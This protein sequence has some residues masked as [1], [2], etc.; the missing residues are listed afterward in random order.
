[1]AITTTSAWSSDVLINYVTAEVR[2]LEPMLHLTRLGVQRDVPKG[3]HQLAFPQTSRIATSSVSTISE[4]VDPTAVTWGSTAYT[5]GITQY[6]LIVQV[7]DV[8]VRNSAIEVIDAAIRQVKFALSRKIDNALQ[9]TVTG[10][11]YG[12]LYA[13]GKSARTELGAGDIIDTVTYTKAIR[14]LAGINSAGLMP[15]EGSYYAVVM[16]PNAEFDLMS[17][18]GAGG[19]LDVGRYASVDELKKGAIGD[20]RGGRILRSANVQ[21]ST[22]NVT[23]Y[24]NMFLGHESFGWGYFQPITPE[25][26]TTPDSN[27]AL[28]LYTSIGAK[29]GIGSTRFEDASTS[30]YRIVDLESAVTS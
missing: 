10:G 17:N 14:N 16:H 7:S 18:T 23:V 19:W 25:M 3:Y 4:S 5:S 12:H 20:F 13:G 26:V 22:S 8:L 27:N 1:M 9:T 15:F 28:M 24:H 11:T 6:G 29:A 30:S 2:T 21:T